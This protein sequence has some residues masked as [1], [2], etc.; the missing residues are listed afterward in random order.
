MLIGQQAHVTTIRKWI[1]LFTNQNTFLRSETYD[2]SD[3][4]WRGYIWALCNDLIKA[5]WLSR[6]ARW[7]NYVAIT[8]MW[9]TN[10]GAH[11]YTLHL[12]YIDSGTTYPIGAQ[13]ALCHMQVRGIV[14]N[15]LSEI[16]NNA[17]TP[18]ITEVRIL[19]M[20]FVRNHWHW[21]KIRGLKRPCSLVWVSMHRILIRVS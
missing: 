13:H 20:E 1:P 15:Y 21:L 10:S 6:V 3:G 9:I 16:G 12:L 11:D 8:E 5:F 7:C 17:R 2:Q 4:R 19:S 14:A 18:W